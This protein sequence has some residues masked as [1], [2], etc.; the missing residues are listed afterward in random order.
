MYAASEGAEGAEGAAPGE[1]GATAGE[2][3]EDVVDA[4]IVDEDGP[5]D[6]EKK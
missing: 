2:G 5:D 1:P 4:E 3:D 6:G